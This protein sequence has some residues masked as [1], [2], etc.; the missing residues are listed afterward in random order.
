LNVVLRL[1]ERSSLA[2][3][4]KSWKS[5]KAARG[6]T[7]K[8]QSKLLKFLFKV[9]YAHAMA[10]PASSGPHSQSTQLSTNFKGSCCCCCCCMFALKT[11]FV[12]PADPA[13]PRDD[14]DDQDDQVD[15]DDEDV[16]SVLEYTTCKPTKQL[17]PRPLIIRFKPRTEPSSWP[18]WTRSVAPA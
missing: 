8:V 16:R 11:H 17:G 9:L 7:S 5:S 4:L 13:D 14:D 2:G 15:D 6:S 1:F 3:S 18:D 12:C 10:S